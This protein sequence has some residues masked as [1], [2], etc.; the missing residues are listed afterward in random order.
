MRFVRSIF[1]AMLLMLTGVSLGAAEGPAPP[2]DKCSAL[3]G[4]VLNDVSITAAQTVPAGPFAAPKL[5]QTLSLPVFCRVQATAR[6]TPDSEIKFEVWLPPKAAWNGK[7]EGTGTGGYDGSISYAA[8]GEAVTRGYAVTSTDM[9]HTGGDLKFGLGHP[10]KVRDW[11]YRAIHVTAIAAKLVARNHYGHW[12]DH[13]YFVGCATGGHQALSEA[14]RYPDDYDGIVAGDPGNDRLNET[15]GYMGAWLALH[16]ASGKP[17]LT[18]ADLQMVTRAAVAQ[19]D[20]LDGVKDGVID[21]PRRCGFD[22]ASLRCKR[23]ETVGCLADIQIAA[24]R[25]VYAGTH[26]PRTGGLIFPGWSIGSEGYGPAAN[27]GWGAW[28]LNPTVPMRS[29]VYNDFVFYNPDWDFRTFDF[30][31]DVAYAQN[32]IPWLAAE[33]RDLDAFRAAGGKL[34][35]YA[36]WSDPV[37]SA[38]DIVRYGTDVTKLAGARKADSFFRFYMVPGMGHCSGGPGTTHFDMLTALEGWAEKGHAP[39][40]VIGSRTLDGG[41][42]R[43][44]PLCVYPKVARWTGHGSTDVAA[45]FVCKVAK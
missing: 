29:E 23:G 33:D 11:A 22:P 41:G 7:F 19:C 42:E 1:G 32:S 43:T 45:N 10:E 4:L 24:I 20:T 16:D 17:L 6:P 3:S 31:R 39:E 30:D 37:A 35:L 14:Q 18:Q 21:D 34:I 38:A 12:P 44:R 40:D 2:A 9:G 26:N 13:S 36:G 27:D 25:K 15:A 8:L 28:L 5:R